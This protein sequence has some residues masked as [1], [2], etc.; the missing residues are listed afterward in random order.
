MTRRTIAEL[1]AQANA[2]LADNNSEAISAA[3]VRA[4]L[5]D[6]F[7]T[8]SPS[9]GALNQS[10]LTKALTPTPSVLAFATVQRASADYVCDAAA[11][12]IT[13]ARGAVAKVATRFT[14]LG[15]VS[16]ANGSEVTVQIFS[17]GAAE[18]FLQQV[19][20]TTGSANRSAFSIDGLQ[21]AI[22]DT[23]YTL[24]VSAPSDS[25]TFFNVVWIAENVPCASAVLGQG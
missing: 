19:V 13:R 21:A 8:I 18:P 3:D 7:D 25:Y 9:F 15:E 14:V 23:S 10:Q 5:L 2:N 4:L 22:V 20:T 12:T 16:G 1:V 11:G 17:N 6:L 24:R